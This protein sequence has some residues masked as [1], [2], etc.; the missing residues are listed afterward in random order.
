MVQGEKAVGER[1]IKGMGSTKY[2]KINLME[3]YH[4]GDEEEITI[5]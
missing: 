5:L 4:G 2:F 3:Q 1:F